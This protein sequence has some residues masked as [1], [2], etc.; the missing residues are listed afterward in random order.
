[1]KTRAPFLTA[2]WTNVVMFN[3]EVDA[4]LLGQFVPAGT[5][6]DTFEG[7]N[8]LSLVGFEF[9]RT[10]LSG[11]AVPFHQAFE[12]VNLRFYVKRSSRRGV[13][14]IREFVPKYAVA[15]IARFA[16]HENYRCV[17]MSHRIENHPDRC[18]ARAEYSWGSAADQCSIRIE[19]EE[20]LFL[21]QQGSPD[22]F[23]SEHYWGYSAQAD[24]GCMEY[25]VQHP[26]W[27][28][29]RARS[30]TF[31]GSAAKLYDPAFAQVLMRAPDHAF[32]ANGSP[33]A[34]S[35]GVRI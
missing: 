20:S 27:H 19:T 2:E 7:R 5:E 8:Y 6:L 14:F 28:V 25:E 17:S 22:Q 29:Q 10:R 12:E 3:Y 23:I 31:T 34:V 33:V 24:G 15:A 26:P 4:A 13:A 21:P 32:L 35:K 18:I 16:Y 11:F 9:N 30:V 1:M